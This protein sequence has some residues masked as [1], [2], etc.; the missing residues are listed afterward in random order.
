[1][2]RIGRTSRGRDVVSEAHKASD[3]GARERSG[4]GDGMDEIRK[5]QPSHPRDCDSLPAVLAGRVPAQLFMTITGVE[6]PM[7]S[8]FEGGLRMHRG[9]PDEADSRVTRKPTAGNV[10]REWLIT[11]EW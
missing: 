3:S 11:H 9:G 1:M 2:V 4:S 8:R 7:D 5:R 6:Q 10:T